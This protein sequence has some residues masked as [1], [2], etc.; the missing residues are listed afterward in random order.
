M[1]RGQ[2]TSQTDAQ[3]LSIVVSEI[4]KAHQSILIGANRQ[5]QDI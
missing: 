5:L 3:S 4:L 2:R 1:E